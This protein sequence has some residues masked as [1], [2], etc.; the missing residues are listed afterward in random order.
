LLLEYDPRLRTPRVAQG[1][2][3]LR[4]CPWTNEHDARGAV[5]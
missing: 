2:A 4:H 1:A 3:A 5:L